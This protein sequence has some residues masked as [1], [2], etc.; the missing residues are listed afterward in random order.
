MANGSPAVRILGYL[1]RD[2]KV[3]PKRLF[4]STEELMAQPLALRIGPRL[5]L[6]SLIQAR[7]IEGPEITRHSPTM[8]KS[9]VY[10]GFTSSDTAFRITP[11]PT[12]APAVNASRVVGS[13]AFLGTALVTLLSF[14]AT[15]LLMRSLMALD[16]FL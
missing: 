8:T 14:S 7:N 1:A 6:R 11:A 2:V 5:R 15:C 13:K 16:Y 10:H 3:T 4:T 9:S 12:P